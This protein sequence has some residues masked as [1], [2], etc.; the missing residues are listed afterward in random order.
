MRQG[1]G[2]RKDL[3]AQAVKSIATYCEPPFV[4]LVRINAQQLT[5]YFGSWFSENNWNHQHD[6]EGGCETACS[7]EFNA[8]A[9]RSE[10]YLFTSITAAP[11][12]VRANT[13]RR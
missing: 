1:P 11:I 6:G 12:T 7:M 8:S 4:P 9:A 10:T 13:T 3:L 2:L 5:R